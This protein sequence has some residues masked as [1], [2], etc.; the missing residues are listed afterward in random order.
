LAWASSGRSEVVGNAG[1]RMGVCD[2]PERYRTVLLFGPPGAGK[3]T[4]GNL[5]G[6]IPGFFHLSCGEVFRTIDINSE[7]GRQFREYSSRG[8]LVP[9]DVTISVWRENLEGQIKLHNFHPDSELLLLDG[10]PRNVNQA[11]LM[12]AQLDVLLILHLHCSDMDAFVERLQKRAMKEK[13]K[14]DAKEEVIR[15]RLKVY[16]DETRPVL[17]HYPREL[18]REIDAL[19]TPVAV[20]RRVLDEL[21][22]VFEKHYGDNGN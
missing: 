14:D 2:V 5:L 19:G 3:G 10:I 22:P 13:R 7:L 21:A 6:R 4:Q 17:E 18:V 15:R 16:E 12:E 8:E 1:R 11:E 9:D 20:L